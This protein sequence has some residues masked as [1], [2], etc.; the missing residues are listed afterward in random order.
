MKKVV[1][2]H[3]LQ[4]YTKYFEKEVMFTANNCDFPVSKIEKEFDIIFSRHENLYRAIILPSEDTRDKP[5]T[6]LLTERIKLRENDI[7]LSDSNPY[8]KLKLFIYPKWNEVLKKVVYGLNV[9]KSDT[10]IVGGFM[11]DD[12]V[13]KFAWCAK[14]HGY[15]VFIDE[16]IS[17]YFYLYLKGYILGIDTSPFTKFYRIEDK[18]KIIQKRRKILF[19]SKN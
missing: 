13:E 12:C 7:V 19:D 9:K 10:L 14:K 5:D 17:D 15:N 4:E 3:P 8:K 1:I 6:S 2:I 11:L 16:L 18:Q